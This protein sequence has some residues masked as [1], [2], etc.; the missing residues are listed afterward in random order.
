MTVFR[1]LL[2]KLKT[3]Y[4]RDPVM[5]QWQQADFA[6][7]LYRIAAEASP[8][9]NIVISP[10]GVASLF[11]LL[12]AGA[13]KTTAKEMASALELEGNGQIET[14]AAIFKDARTTLQQAVNPS[15]AVEL[16]DSL[17]LKKDFK[18]FPAFL[19][20]ARV[21]FDADVRMVEMG[22]NARQKINAFVSDKTHKLI[23][24]LLEPGCPS[25]DSNLVAIDTIYLK[26]KWD[27]PFS[28]E[29]TIED[30]V[31]H[32][33]DGDCKVSAMHSIRHAEILDA[34]DCA[35]LR[36]PYFNNTAEMLV[37]L[38]SSNVSLS[39][40]EAHFSQNYLEHLATSPWHGE[41][42]ITLPKFNFNSTHN[43]KHL[44][45]KMGMVTPFDEI[46]ADFS[47]LA[48]AP[49]FISEALQ[50]AKIIVDEDG[51]EAAAATVALI[52]IGC[53][54]PFDKPPPREF[55]CDRPF[56]FMVRERKTGL[57]LFM[58]RV[59]KPTE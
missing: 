40:L 49:L 23:P 32:S 12:L 27:E 25:P 7:N 38:P 59:M 36:L 37:M 29:D 41:V 18:V 35:A 22:E 57:V 8:N 55:K 31:F 54:P 15:V 51:T 6:A 17:W 39:D 53:P 20:L 5:A 34:P 3:N 46:G 45:P 1:S 10:W 24:E 16:S 47:G 11:A 56:I 42:S 48:E 44:L 52:G 28:E 9:D 30:E 21:A 26:A 50:K 19:S 33:P 58:G 43:L 13:R 4:F 14:V 2:D